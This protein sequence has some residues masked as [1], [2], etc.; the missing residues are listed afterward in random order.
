MKATLNPTAPAQA[1]L[2]FHEQ[3][4][5]VGIT[6]DGREAVFHRHVPMTL[7]VLAPDSKIH[8]TNAGYASY[9]CRCGS[10]CAAS[11]LTYLRKMYGT[12][13]GEVRAHKE[14]QKYWTD[15]VAAMPATPKLLAPPKPV[16][17]L[18]ESRPE[19][20]EAV[21]VRVRAA[22]PGLVEILDLCKARGV[23]V[24]VVVHVEA[25]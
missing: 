8:G 19:P 25:R 2:K 23:D 1:T 13:A 6:R 20:A 18:P 9:G 12:E 24:R 15:K 4:L 5:E 22:K 10:C 17:M 11:R 16:L 3:H 7:G 21:T 14:V